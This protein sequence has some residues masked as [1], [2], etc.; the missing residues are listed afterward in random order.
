MTTY[1]D[2]PSLR[3]E[4]E[5]TFTVFNLSGAEVPLQTDDFLS[6]LQRVEQTEEVSFS[7]IEL[8]Y[9]DDEQIVDLNREHLGR[10]YV[11]DIITFGYNCN[12]EKD[13]IE[14]TLYCCAQRIKEQ[15]V[16]LGIEAELEF[17]RVFVHGLLHLAGYDDAS[18][19][20]K[21]K[22]RDREDRI[23]QIRANNL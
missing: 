23:L 19:D 3:N 5:E 4:P 15:S 6:L 13:E 11:T 16:E 17:S 20:E 7:E 2:F 14:G 12:F 21:E 22:M 18:E 8:V 1:P 9:V 10:D